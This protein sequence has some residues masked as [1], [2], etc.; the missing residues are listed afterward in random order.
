MFVTIL[1]TAVGNSLKY[2]AGPMY[3]LAFSGNF[4]VA[5]TNIGMLTANLTVPAEW[6]PPELQVRSITIAGMANIVGMGFGLVVS[7]YTSIPTYNF[8]LAVIS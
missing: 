4:I 8:I 7:V 6:F 2:A 1:A 5:V 3:G